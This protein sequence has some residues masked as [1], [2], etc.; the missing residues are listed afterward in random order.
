MQCNTTDS[1]I[2]TSKYG[3]ANNPITNKDPSYEIK[4]KNTSDNAF[5]ALNISIM[6]KTE[7]LRVDAFYLPHEKYKHGSFEKSYFP[8]LAT[9]KSYQS[10]HSAQFLS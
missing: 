8:K 10:W 6:T 3:L 9:L 4:N 2:A 1:A 5:K 7:R